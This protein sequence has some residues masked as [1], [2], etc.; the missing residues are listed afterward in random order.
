MFTEQY[1]DELLSTPSQAL[2]EA[3]KKLD[4][5]I[6]ILGAGGKVGPTLSLMA[7]RAVDAANG[8][9]GSAC[10]THDLLI[11]LFIAQH[12]GHFQPLGDALHFL[13]GQH[14]FQKAIG[15]FF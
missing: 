6:M 8:G 2:I 10:L 15:F 3:I 4:G 7:K 14:I 1:L 13:N 12:D 9:C 11:G 5:D